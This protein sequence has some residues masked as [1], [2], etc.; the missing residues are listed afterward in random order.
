MRFYKEK[1]IEN[2]SIFDA[3][4]NLEE[5]VTKMHHIRYIIR[6]YNYKNKM[7]FHFCTFIKDSFNSFS[8][9]NKKADIYI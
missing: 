8:K 4:T 6:D 2:G 7:L 5:L 3:T 1:V 9:L